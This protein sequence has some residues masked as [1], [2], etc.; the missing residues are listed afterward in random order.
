[1]TQTIET[2]AEGVP[3]IKALQNGFPTKPTSIAGLRSGE[4]KKYLVDEDFHNRQS[5]PP[6]DTTAKNRKSSPYYDD[7]AVDLGLSDIM[8]IYIC[9]KELAQ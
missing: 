1:M 6:P 2:F 3:G 7:R 8:P 4:S 5:R 9:I